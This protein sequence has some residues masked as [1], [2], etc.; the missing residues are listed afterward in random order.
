[1]GTSETFLTVIAIRL[2]ALVI[3]GLAIR[4]LPEHRHQEL[5]CAPATT[6]SVNVQAPDVPKPSEIVQDM[7]M[8]D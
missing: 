2:G 6:Q 3:A 8:H 5:T 1:M 7:L 4:A